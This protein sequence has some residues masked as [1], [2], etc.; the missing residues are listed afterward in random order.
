[1]ELTTMKSNE[2]PRFGRRVW[3]RQWIALI[4]VGAT[5]SLGPVLVAADAPGIDLRDTRMLAEPALSARQ[6]AFTYDNDIWIADLGASADGGR[7]ARR[8]TSHE[9]YESNP[10]FSPD[11]KLL[12]FSGEYDGNIDVYVVP[13]EGGSPLRLTWHPGPDFV[14]GFTPDGTAVLFNSPRSVHTLRHVQLFTV[15]IAGGFPTRLPIP[16][17][18]HASYSPDGKA[19]A[20]QPLAEVH[21][22]WKHYRGG[23]TARIWLYDFPG[24]TVAQ[25]PQPPERSND[26]DPMWIGNQ[27]FFRSDRAGE[28]NLF[29]FDRGTSEVRQLTRFT[30]FPVLA[31]SA[32]SA[33]PGSRIVFEQGGWIHVLDTATGKIERLRIG[34][35]SDLKDRRPRFE[36]GADYARSGDLSPSGA[37]AV[38]EFRGEIV[39]VPAEK[40]SPRNLTQTTGANER[41]PV[42]SADGTRIAFFSDA[43]G[44][45]RLVVAPQDGGGE[46]H[47]YDLAGAGFYEDID[48][49]PDGKFISYA[50]NSWSLYVL[51]LEN[52]AIDHVGSEH[53]YGPDRGRNLHH[54]WSPD[55]KWLAY[56]L[57][58]GTYIQEVFLYSVKDKTSHAV[59]DGLS[60]VSEPVFDAGGKYLYFFASTDA[61][62]VKQWFSMASADMVVTRSLY[63]AVLA[64]GVESPFKPESDEEKGEAAKETPDDEHPATGAA[65][66]G[67][68]ESA[69]KRAKGGEG[70]KGG[71]DAG[72]ETT[73]V[74]VKVDF[75]GL[76]QRIV[77]VPI[78]PAAYSNLLAGKEGKVFY[79]RSAKPGG[80]PGSLRV[81]DLEK[82]EEKTLLGDGVRRFTIS[83][84]RGK[85]LYVTDDAWAIATIGAEPIDPAKGRLPIDQ[86]EV[87]IDPAAEWP[88]IFNEAWRINRDYFYDPGMHGADWPAMREKYAAFLPSIVTRRD[89]NRVIQWMGSELAVGHHRVAGGDQRLDRDAMPGGLLGADFEVANGRYR[90]AKVFGGL[91]WNPT[92][93]APLTAPGVDAVAGEYLLAVDGRELFASE[94]VYSRF[95]KTAGKNVSITLGPSPDGKG[96]RTVT[97]VPIEDEGALRNRDW[98][99]GNLRRVKEAT[100]GR[101]AYVYVPNTANL[102]HTYFKRYFFPQ[103]DKEAIIVD[104]RH[105]GGG[106]VADYYIDHLRRPFISYW[107]TRYGA[108]LETPGAAIH[109][110]KVMI[111][112]ET[113]GSGGDLLPW[114]FRKLEL[115]KLVGR[116]TWGGLVGVLGFPVLMDGGFITAPNLAFWT[117]DGF[118]VENEGVP[119]DVEVEQWPAE[120]EAGHDPQLE[121]AIAIVLEE[122]EKNPRH[123]PERP[124]FPNRVKPSA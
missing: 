108:D 43:S 103:A 71:S 98:V 68:P 40:G 3:A 54:S 42:W 70:A 115:G 79:L 119:P 59:T 121:K 52:G 4:A 23:T 90:I 93:R 83:R 69:S 17:G 73:K 22:E 124:P 11:G 78:E 45:Y 66:P 1:M 62:P 8:I 101:V 89:L 60:E 72:E 29:S 118:L 86:V 5:T 50:D 61:G 46:P 123:R 34:A 20:Y 94:D 114:M 109:G 81:Y 7:I 65:P 26:V 19:I 41:S 31:A 10:R 120:V 92:L 63:L 84:D 44:E 104:E 48:W 102:G 116:R 91:N 56:T 14:E 57:H 55:S 32:E 111:I 75:E 99:E 95:E 67:E 88:Q 85:V 87:K 100:G 36:K 58:T 113:A 82:R 53:L 12:A 2:S 77:A 35:A 15:P 106:Q 107:A 117:E 74:E 105:N 16:H 6:V 18:L 76:D 47:A 9:G 27:I 51:E 97:V 24:K 110:P 64:K 33:A 25:V 39:T 13:V 49:S 96:A 37:R 112:D 80:G 28:I 30:D 38:I 21:E 122:L